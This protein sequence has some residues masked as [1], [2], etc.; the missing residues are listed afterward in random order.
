MRLIGRNVK[1]GIVRLALDDSEDLWMLR[2]LIMPGDTVKGVSTRKVKVTEKEAVKKTYTFVLEVEKT[3]YAGD[4]L[5]VLGIVLN[6]IDDVPKGSH[7]SI[8]LSPGDSFSLKK[9]WNEYY[10]KRLEDSLQRSKSKSVMVLFDRDSALFYE[11]GSRIRKLLELK[12]D[13]KK[14][15]YDT[16]SGNF[17][18]EVAVKALEISS[19]NPII[20]CAP[21]FW[22]D[23]IKKEVSSLHNIPKSY[24]IPISDVSESSLKEIA[25]SKQVSSIL[26]SSQSIKELSAMQELLSYISKGAKSSYGISQVRE[27]TDAGAIETLIISSKLIEKHLEKDE[28]GIIDSIMRSALNSKATIIIVENH[29]ESRRQLDSLGGIAAILRY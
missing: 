20:F 18:R 25:T 22:I 7:Q 19:G 6:E 24:Y 13:S 29:E 10:D 23:E 1:E 28:F 8:V 27:M 2:M 15:Q 11:S 5:R 14:K 17:I 26:S 9:E 16:K 3:E 4:S 21:G 12:G